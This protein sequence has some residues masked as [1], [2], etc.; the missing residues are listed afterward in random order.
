M[1]KFVIFIQKKKDQYTVLGFRLRFKNRCIKS[2][3]GR[4][5]RGL[6]EAIHDGLEKERYIV[7]IACIL[8]GQQLDLL[9]EPRLVLAVRII[10]R[11]LV[12]VRKGLYAYVLLV[13]GTLD[14]VYGVV[15]DIVDLHFGRRYG[16]VVGGRGAERLQCRQSTLQV[17]LLYDK[18][19]THTC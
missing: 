9:V 17:M 16:V 12:V 6:L 19:N 13:F 3:I 4:V 5:R 7:Y 2:Y 18:K 1:R 10:V 11:I 8:A 15:L 14:V